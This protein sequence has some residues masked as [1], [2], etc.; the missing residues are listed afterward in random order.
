LS[1]CLSVCSRFKVQTLCCL[2]ATNFRVKLF[3]IC[4][5]ASGRFLVSLSSIT[6]SHFT[7]LNIP[8]PF[9]LDNF[10]SLSNS[11]FICQHCCK[12]SAPAQLVQDNRETFR[13]CRLVG[14]RLKLSASI[15]KPAAELLFRSQFSLTRQT[16]FDACL[17]KAI[18]KNRSKLDR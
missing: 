17:M 16:S 9:Q 12:T 4:M 7:N 2:V 11:F 14:S 10:N 6:S 1:V 3:V 8:I 18:C 13:D 5:M 15:L